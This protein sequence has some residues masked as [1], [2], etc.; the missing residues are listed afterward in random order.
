MDV[1]TPFLNGVF[2]S[3]EVYEVMIAD[4][5]RLVLVQRSVTLG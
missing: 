1:Q 2:L 3:H 5:A 4:V